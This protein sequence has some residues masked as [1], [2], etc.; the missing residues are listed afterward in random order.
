MSRSGEKG[1]V[2][3]GV[4]GLSVLLRFCVYFW[5]RVEDRQI[6]KIDNILSAYEN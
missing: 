3:G 6:N 2:V 4:L 5:G 1:G